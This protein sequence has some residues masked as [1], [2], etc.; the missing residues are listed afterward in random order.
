MTRTG[1]VI[2][3]L[4]RRRARTI[5]TLLSITAAF[6]LFG[7]LQ[8]VN[9]MF[10]RPADFIGITRLI[11]QARVSFTQPLPMRLLPQ[12]EG[13]PGVDRVAFIL[14]FGGK[15]PDDSPIFALATDPMRLRDVSPQWVMSDA[16]WQSF[17]N[18]RT[19]VIA[20]KLMADQYHWKVGDR[21][22]IKDAI[23]PQKDGS[24]DW[25]FDLVGIFDGKDE[26]AHRQ[27]LRAYLNYAYVDEANANGQGNVSFFVERMSDPA[28]A[29]AAARTIDAKFENSPEETKTQTEQDFT[30]GFIRQVADIG[31]IVRWIMFAVFFTLLM[32]VGNTMAQAVRERVPELAV[33]KTLGFSD[34][35]VLRF[36]LAEAVTLCLIGGVI[37]LSIATV[38]G[39]AVARTANFPLSVDYRVWLAGAVAIVLMSLATGLLPALRARR[40]TIVDALAGR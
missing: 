23:I 7:L 38:A 22:K 35:S 27:T 10:D 33:L 18:T 28:L 1:F 9:V 3:N 21:V 14:F 39:M 17:A 32:V 11:T 6:L 37:G 26:Q 24:R 13:T 30:V 2:A 19:G 16:Q 15:L 34:G 25:T 5:L 40:L 20:G 4:F 29:G 36:V 31:L 12:I 8:A